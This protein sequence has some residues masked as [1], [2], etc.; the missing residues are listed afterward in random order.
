MVEAL[1]ARGASRLA[2][3]SKHFTPLHHAVINMHL[4]CVLQVVGTPGSPGM[5][6]A[7]VD[8]FASANERITALHI[9]AELGDEKVAAARRPH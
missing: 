7:E 5:T 1:L 4:G 6:P 9:A 2:Q 8:M 3:D